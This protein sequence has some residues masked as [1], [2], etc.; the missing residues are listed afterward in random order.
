MVRAFPGLLAI[1]AFVSLAWA[2]LALR[3]SPHR[4]LRNAVARRGE[5]ADPDSRLIEIFAGVAART[6]IRHTCLHRS[7][8]LQWI[9]ARRGTH[10]RL[11]IGV[12]EKPS[13]LP[14]HAW[15]EIDGRIVNDAPEIVG[16]YRR[17]N[18][19]HRP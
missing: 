3:L 14:G 10:A 16:R 13:L 15:L 11:C 2:R 12:G 8:A 17:L 19:S 5:G 6:P 4:V 9:L 7:L 18:V 1:E